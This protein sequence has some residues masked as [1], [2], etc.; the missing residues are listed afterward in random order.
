MSIVCAKRN[1]TSW[2]NLM[3]VVFTGY[4]ESTAEHMNGDGAGRGMLRQRDFW[5]HRDEDHPHPV[6]FDKRLG[7]PPRS[8]F[9]GR[10]PADFLVQIEAFK[11]AT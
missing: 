7:T 9:G 3:F 4:H 6:G 2:T 8:A 5:F 10:E 11:E 1:Q